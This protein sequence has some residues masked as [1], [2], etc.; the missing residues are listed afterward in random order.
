[1]M[2]IIQNKTTNY[3]AVHGKSDGAELSNKLTTLLNAF[4][5]VYKIYWRFF[6]TNE[7]NY[8]ILIHEL[9]FI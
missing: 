1:M 2:K 5:A 3:S 4:K 6:K 9:K 7:S 8:Y